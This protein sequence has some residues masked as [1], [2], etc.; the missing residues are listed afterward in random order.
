MRRGGIFRVLIRP[1]LH[2]LQALLEANYG[3]CE[4]TTPASYGSKGPDQ[5]SQKDYFHCF[6]PSS[7]SKFGRTQ[8]KALYDL[9]KA[10]NRS[11]NVGLPSKAV[12]VM[13]ITSNAFR[14]LVLTSV[15]EAG[16]DDSILTL[17]QVLKCLVIT[18]QGVFSNSSF[19]LERIRGSL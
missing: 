11:Y 7:L 16:S 18:E 8:H 1:A 19:A 3:F 17:N 5:T 6:R 14:D 9:E 15:R 2:C 12:G 4:S 10:L 13:F